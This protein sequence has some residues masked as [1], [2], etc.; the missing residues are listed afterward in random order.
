MQ[1]IVPCLWFDDKAEEAAKFYTSVFKNSKVGKIS[2]YSTETPS[3]KPVG[4]VLTVSFELEGLKFVG[5][6][7]GPFFKLNPSISFI[8]G[9]E[10]KDEVNTLWN[11]LGEGGKVL[12]PLD[13]YPFSEWYGWTEDKYGVSWQLILVSPVGSDMPK[14]VPS[15]LFVGNNYGNADKAVNFYLSVFNNSK[16]GNLMKYGPGQEPNKEGTVMFCDFMIENF[17]LAAM[18][19]GGEHN[20]AFNE[21]LSF[22]IYCKNQEEIDYFYDKLSVVPEAEV[23]GWLKDK[24]GV[25]WQLVTKKID[26]L[27]EDEKVMKALLEMKRLDVRKLEEIYNN[28]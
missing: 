5:L 6:N 14:I 17:W 2:R 24:F 23:C 11:K 12:M 8:V 22:I 15:L 9:C 20:F 16:V 3:N 26:E 7:G 1:K 25:S 19:G 10:S 4:S 27:I 13:K 28:K 18:D 21:A